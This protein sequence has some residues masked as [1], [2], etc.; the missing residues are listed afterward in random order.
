MSLEQTPP[1]RQTTKYERL[2][3]ISLDLASTLDLD[4]LLIRI[5][6]VACELSES[7]QSSIL[8]YDE[9]TQQLFFQTRPVSPPI[10]TCVAWLSR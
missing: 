10:L 4:T 9:T 6:G 7:E 2:I 1:E 3:E 5:V 8:L